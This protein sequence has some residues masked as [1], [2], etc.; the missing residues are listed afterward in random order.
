VIGHKS[1]LLSKTNTK[2]S[3]GLLSFA[4]KNKLVEIQ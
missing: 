2:S 3:V 1:N 4:I